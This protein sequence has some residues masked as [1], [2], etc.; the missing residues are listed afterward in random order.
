MSTSLILLLPEVFSPC[1]GQSPCFLEKLRL[2]VSACCQW[3]VL[4]LMA[5]EVG[6]G[7]PG[8]FCQLCTRPCPRCPSGCL[9]SGLTS[10]ATEVLSVEIQGAGNR[11]QSQALPHEA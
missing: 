2:N 9:G 10:G 7:K 5:L 6:G 8:S 4:S 3:W 11:T 1:Q